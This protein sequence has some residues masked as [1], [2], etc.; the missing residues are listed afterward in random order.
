MIQNYDL[1]KI[2]KK[3]LSRGGD[4]SEIFFERSDSA[5]IQCEEKRI[6]KILV[7]T[8]MGVGIR[9]L[10]EG[11][12]AY[13]FT[14][15]LEE[16]SLLRLAETVAQ[17]VKAKQFQKEINLA[18]RKPPWKN[19]VQI[20]PTSVPFERKAALVMKANDTAWAFDP[21]IQQVSV[22][23]RDQKRKI[24]IA[25]SE[26]EACEDDQT[27]TIFVVQ[28]VAAENDVVQT[29]YEPVGGTEGFE[30]FGK[31]SPEETALIAARQALLMLKARKAPAGRMPT[32]LSAEAGG[33]MI[34]E[35]VG[36]GL[37]ADLA[38]EG[39]SVYQNRIG[40]AIASPLITVLDDKTLPG[41]RGSFAFDDE[42]TPAER[43]ILVENGILKKYMYNRLY[44][45]KAGARS[46]GNGRRQSYRHRPICRMT[47]TMIASGKDDP[48]AI[49]RSVEKGLFVKKMGGGQVNTVNGD[50]MF[51]VTEGYLLEKGKV[52]EP[53]RGAT[54]TGNGP[55]IL[56]IIDK[57]GSD[58]GFGLGTCGK[59]GQGVPVADAQ[60][61]LRIPEIVVGGAA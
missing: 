52:G 1:N 20:D 29:G 2:L 28:V 47:N 16:G 31:T 33:T 61:T 7:G 12:T 5:N 4:F 50:F 24:F 3:A 35:A 26:G 6:E 46:T 38:L 9:V 43:T 17:A 36:H 60:P 30:L 45:S 32:V 34:H 56:K 55:E 49:V 39:I 15:R 18:E 22:S 57:V 27:Y 59:D 51:E 23:Y 25:N 8:E 53:V 21:H 44:A 19:P 10:F 14:N 13:A 11:E 54:L 42:G 48:A 41:K 37:E 58:L 40:E